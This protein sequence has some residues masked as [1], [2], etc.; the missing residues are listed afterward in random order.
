[1]S[2]SKLPLTSRGFFSDSGNFDYF[3]QCA[4]T[5]VKERPGTKLNTGNNEMLRVLFGAASQL[6]VFKATSKKLTWQEKLWTLAA[7]W[8]FE[9]EPWCYDEVCDAPQSLDF[10]RLS[11]RLD[12]ELAALQEARSLAVSDFIRPTADNPTPLPYRDPSPTRSE[13][14]QNLTAAQEEYFRF[15]DGVILQQGPPLGTPLRPYTS[16]QEDPT[17]DGIGSPESRAVKEKVYKALPQRSLSIEV[18]ERRNIEVQKQ[19]NDAAQRN[20]EIEAAAQRNLEIE[21]AAQRSLEIEAAAQQRLRTEAETERQLLAKELE[22]ARLKL[23]AQ[24]LE[25]ELRQ[26]AILEKEKS[27]AERILRGSE[28]HKQAQADLLA[29][30]ALAAAESTKL[31]LAPLLDA[32]VKS[33]DA[34]LEANAKELDAHARKLEANV[35]ETKLL[36]ESTAKSLNARVE[37]LKIS[38]DARSSRS[39]ASSQYSQRTATSRK[40]AERSRASAGSK[41]SRTPV[42][43]ITE[44]NAPPRRCEPTRSRRAPRSWKSLTTRT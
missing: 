2:K 22:N 16:S 6:G 24:E 27:D 40:N 21:A 3:A 7:Y 31:A 19:H 29:A 34:K 36:V 38:N 35:Q 18:Q 41:K 26:V 12:K 8:G 43:P 33:L 30:Q 37:E 9:Q 5:F 13:P 1:V 44:P 28:R 23:R 15:V 11:S 17:P 25:K 14:E 39:H 20:L 32:H 4:D 42:D 10:T